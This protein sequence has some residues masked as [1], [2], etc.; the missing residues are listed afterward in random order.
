MNLFSGSALLPLLPNLIT[1]TRLFSV[2][3]MV[4]LIL[5]QRFAPAFWL[6]VAAG[7]SDALDG[8]LARKL[9]L[10]STVGAFLDPLADKALLVGVYVTL[11][12]MNYV[13]EWLVIIVVFRDI[14][15]IGGAI[16]YQ[17]LTQ[18]LK[19][20]PLFVSKVNTVAQIGLA[21][22]LLARQGL[23]FNDFGLTDYLVYAVAATT[24]VSGGA[25]VFVWGRRYIGM[26]PSK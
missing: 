13:A 14:I 4:W 12:H 2:P 24:I 6:F 17:T 5:E 26:E 21:A 23:G 10:R 18:S 3:L 15:I 16:L 22:L 20:Q 19:M 8:F 25:Y 11:G 7:V 9:K 1:L